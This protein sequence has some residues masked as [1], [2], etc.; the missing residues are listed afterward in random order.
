MTFRKAKITTKLV[1]ALQPEE[2]VADTSLP[3]FMVRRGGGERV[4]CDRECHGF[5]PQ[6]TGGAYSIFCGGQITHAPAEKRISVTEP[7]KKTNMRMLTDQ[8]RAS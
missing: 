7:A 3:G 8:A 4:D 2:M 1:E 5:P 6:I